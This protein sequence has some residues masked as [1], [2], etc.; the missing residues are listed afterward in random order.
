MDIT[1]FDGWTLVNGL[2]M[3]FKGIA[4]VVLAYYTKPNDQ[5]PHGAR[6]ELT[7]AWCPE[8][9]QAVIA[10]TTRQGGLGMHSSRPSRQ[11][12]QSQV[13]S[14]Q[15]NQGNRSWS[16]NRGWSWTS[17]EGWTWTE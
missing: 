8:A 14:G 4:Y 3:V 7:L 10:Q 6:Q 15:W 1:G 11:R 2:S 13:T 16:S 12:S 5:T 17:A 9:P